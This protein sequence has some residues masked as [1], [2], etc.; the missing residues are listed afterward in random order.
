MIDSKQQYREF[1]KNISTI[2]NK[3]IP[4]HKGIRKRNVL[5]VEKRLI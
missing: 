3:N 4:N 2:K 1:V 5:K